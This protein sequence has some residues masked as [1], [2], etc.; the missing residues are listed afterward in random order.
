MGDRGSER[1]A[2]TRRR[3][4][5]D[6]AGAVLESITDLPLPAREALALSDVARP[7]MPL[8]LRFAAGQKP[9]SDLEEDVGWATM[10]AFAR[11]EMLA[12]QAARLDAGLAGRNLGLLDRISALVGSWPQ[13][14]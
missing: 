4:A 11:R 14:E 8:V 2:S 5:R 9:G 12:D 10:V 1:N 6:T 3:S 13:A 7:V